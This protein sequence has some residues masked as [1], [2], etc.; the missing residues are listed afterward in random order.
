MPSL[1][2]KQNYYTKADIKVFCSCP[3]LL[4]FLT[5]FHV[6]S[7]IYRTSH[8]ELFLGKGVLNICSKFTGEHPC[9]SAISIKLQSNLA[10]LPNFRGEMLSVKCFWLKPQCYEKM[11]PMIVFV[12][13]LSRGVSNECTKYLI[14]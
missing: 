2:Q 7:D 14:C 9:Q 13:S 11:E 6:L 8:P 3:V 10:F 4:D 5:S 1:F 12:R